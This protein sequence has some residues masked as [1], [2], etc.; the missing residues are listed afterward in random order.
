MNILNNISIKL[1]FKILFASILGTFIGN[2][3]P[4]KSKIIFIIIAII[5]FNVIWEMSNSFIYG[6]KIDK[7]K[8][9]NDTG[10]TVV[11]LMVLFLPIY[12]FNNDYSFLEIIG[13]TICMTAITIF[14]YILLKAYFKRNDLI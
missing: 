13:I 14:G 4:H 12:L 1:I 3:P 9:F 10:N 2:M 11:G 5:L 8:S 7:T 6:N